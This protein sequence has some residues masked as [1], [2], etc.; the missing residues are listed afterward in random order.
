[1]W[2]SLLVRFLAAIFEVLDQTGLLALAGILCD[3]VMGI[4]PPAQRRPASTLGKVL[5]RMTM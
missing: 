2:R 4:S 1:M 5:R 3:G